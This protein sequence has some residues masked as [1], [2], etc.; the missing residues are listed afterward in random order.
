MNIPNLANRNNPYYVELVRQGLRDRANQARVGSILQDA[1]VVVAVG[2]G[3]GQ[4]QDF[5]PGH[6]VAAAGLDDNDDDGD[7]FGFDPDDEGEETFVDFAPNAH[8]EY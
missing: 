5:V 8:E 7:D 6:E 4:E 2:G 1:D 3:G